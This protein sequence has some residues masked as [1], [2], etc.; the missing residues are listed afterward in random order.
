[1][2][3]QPLSVHLTRKRNFTASLPDAKKINIDP[4]VTHGTRNVTYAGKISRGPARSITIIFPDNTKICEKTAVDTLYK[5]VEYV[6]VEKVRKVVIDHQLIFCKVPVISNRRD[7]KYRH[8]QKKLSNGWLLMTHSNNSMKRD[9]IQK[10]SDVLHL[11]VNVIM[12]E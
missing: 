2:P 3:N 10:V 6:G 7:E 8:T 11:G 4:I 12:N 1:M 9:F 5:F